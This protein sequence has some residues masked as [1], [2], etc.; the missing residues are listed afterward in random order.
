M[1]LKIVQAV[2][3]GTVACLLAVSCQTIAAQ[4]PQSFWESKSA[5]PHNGGAFENERK[6]TYIQP[7]SGRY[8]CSS[9]N[10]T[11]YKIVETGGTVL[12][13]KTK[14]TRT[15]ICLTKKERQVATSQQS[16]TPN[17]HPDMD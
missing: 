17:H 10:S 12:G 4:D 7:W 13:E 14:I 6:S 5:G 8:A 11:H 15:G 9:A 2:K 1:K 16:T 3:L